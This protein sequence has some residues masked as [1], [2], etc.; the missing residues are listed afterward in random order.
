MISKLHFHSVKPCRAHHPINKDVLYI[1]VNKDSTF[2][3]LSSNNHFSVPSLAPVAIVLVSPWNTCVCV[4]FLSASLI[5]AEAHLLRMA[6]N[7]SL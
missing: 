5:Q 3:C 1:V 7:L 2:C 6:L 4:F